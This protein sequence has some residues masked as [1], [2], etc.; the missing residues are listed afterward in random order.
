MQSYGKT[1]AARQELGVVHHVMTFAG[2]EGQ[3]QAFSSLSANVSGV[4]VVR[5]I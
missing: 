3:L 2:I 1:T 4:Q 5:I